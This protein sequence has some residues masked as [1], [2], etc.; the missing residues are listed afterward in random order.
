[1]K[2]NLLLGLLIGFSMGVFADKEPVPAAIYLQNLPGERIGQWTDQQII[3][4]LQAQ[5]MIVITHDCSAY[6]TTSPELET[7]ILE[8]H[9]TLAGHLTDYDT[10]TTTIESR[11]MYFIPEGYTYRKVA[12]WNFVDH[13][14]DGSLEYIMR[15]YNQYVVPN[16]GRDSAFVYTD[17]LT[18]TGEQIDYNLY[19]DI[20][21]PTGTATKQVPLLINHSSSDFRQSQTR[22]EADKNTV[23]RTIYQ[24]GC[25]TTGYAFANMDHCYNPVARDVVYKYFDDGYTLDDWDGLASNTACIR[26]LRSHL[27]DYNLNGKIGCMGISKAAYA[28]VRLANRMN[29]TQD[30]HFFF[31]GQPNT[32]EQPWPGVPSTIDVAYA[33][34]GNG[35]RRIPKYV[36]ANTVPMITSVGKSD[37][38]GHW[39]IYPEVVNH[40]DTIDHNHLSMWMEDMGHTFPCVGTDLRTGMN[41]YVLCKRFFDRYLKPTE[42][43]T[44]AILYI[45]P[46]E[47]APVVTTRGESRVLASD[48]VLPENMLGISPYEPITVRYLYEVDTTNLAQK[49]QILDANDEPVTGVWTIHLQGTCLRFIPDSP[50][51]QDATY[52]IIADGIIRAFTITEKADED[53]DVKSTAF[54]VVEDAY[55]KVVKET[56]VRGAEAVLKVR[57]SQ[58]GDWK[59]YSYLKFALDWDSIDATQIKRAYIRLASASAPAAPVVVNVHTADNA[60]SETTLVSTNRPTYS[61]QS[62]GQYTYSG[63]TTWNELEVTG[64]IRT[65]IAS[66]Q[67]TLS[68]ALIAAYDNTEYAN[69]VS[70][71]GAAGL[72]P[73]LV[74]EEF[75]QED[76]LPS[77]LTDIED[78]RIKAIKR[79]EN[80]EITIERNGVVYTILGTRL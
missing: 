37:Q 64:A 58:Y 41:R 28:P 68:F 17:M 65:A 32:H 30:E 18:R 8:W 74:V 5:G 48:G 3:A 59:F 71:E 9:R 52:R 35:T 60:W 49:I 4:D 47:D 78:S 16:L 75:V 31:N 24:L 11:A 22:P 42:V 77:A 39:A 55:T 44:M 70:K 2:R 6:P 14:A 63:V 69:F 79:L 34:A 10:D 19:V 7:A 38:Y 26:Y 67:D 51:T 62:C 27:S 50:L 45:L 21:Y 33:A 13:G 12:V 46:K 54:D 23:Y 57:H 36:D 66:N 72:H 76:P 20:I 25:L 61:A 43:D 1:M 80:G 56:T 73:Q 15:K 40:M 53:K 29:A